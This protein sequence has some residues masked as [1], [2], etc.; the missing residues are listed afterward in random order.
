LGE[1]GEVCKLAPEQAAKLRETLGLF[2]AM[3]Q[4]KL[5]TLLNDESWHS[6][7]LPIFTSIW[8]DVIA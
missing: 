8:T 2:M 7:I 3:P 6:Q 4:N 1:A 5:K